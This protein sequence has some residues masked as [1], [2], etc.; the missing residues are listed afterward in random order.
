MYII[1]GMS[2]HLLNKICRLVWHMV[3]LC[4]HVVG[5]FWQGSE[6]FFFGAATLLHTG[7]AER[8]TSLPNPSR[9]LI[10]S[11]GVCVCV[12]VCAC[13]FVCVFVYIFLYVCICIHACV[14]IYINAKIYKDTCMPCKQTCKQTCK[15]TWKQTH[16]QTHTRAYLCVRERVWD[17]VIEGERNM[18]L[19]VYIYRYAY[20]Y[21]HT[22]A[23]TCTPNALM[24]IYVYSH[25]HT[26]TR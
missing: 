9:R 5:L 7:D 4:C 15:H 11:P 25:T 22:H 16:E 12:H 24:H 14:Q 18:S 10:A 23:H 6:S 1:T 3:G 2:E 19:C 17:F 20:T 21:T 26:H 13:V 8:T